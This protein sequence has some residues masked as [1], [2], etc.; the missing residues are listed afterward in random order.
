VLHHTPEANK[1]P[2]DI[3]HLLGTAPVGTDK[4]IRQSGARAGAVQMALL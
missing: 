4:I 3:T 1:S 2:L